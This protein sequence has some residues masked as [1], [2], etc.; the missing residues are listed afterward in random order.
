MPDLVGE[1]RLAVAALLGGAELILEE[2]VVLRANNGKV[3][4][5]GGAVV[6]RIGDGR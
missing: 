2:R 6:V 3:V 5:H 1:A 4:A